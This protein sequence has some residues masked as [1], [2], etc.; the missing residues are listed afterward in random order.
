MPVCI[1]CTSFIRMNHWRKM[2]AHVRSLDDYICLGGAMC[3][4]C[5]CVVL[6]V[7]STLQKA[8]LKEW[9]SIAPWNNLLN[10]LISTCSHFF[11]WFLHCASHI[12]MNNLGV[13]G[14]MLAPRHH[15]IAIYMH[16]R[17][18]MYNH[19]HIPHK[20]SCHMYFQCTMTPHIPTTRGVS[21]NFTQSASKGSQEPMNI[22]T[23]FL[24]S[25]FPLLNS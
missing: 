25:F 17:N 22:P 23:F 3:G 15:N 1:R 16:H 9:G 4:S 20:T 6:Q 21:F 12:Y 19:I 11:W 10:T 24:F 7:V 13:E 8:R 18:I 5:L 14:H 2:L